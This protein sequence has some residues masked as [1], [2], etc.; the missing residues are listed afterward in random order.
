MGKDGAQ[1]RAIA[2]ECGIEDIFEDEGFVKREQ[3]S[4][5]QDQ[6]HINLLLTSSS[7]E[8]QGVLTGKLFDY[9]ESRRPVLC[10]INGVFDEELEA[11]FNK[12][13]LGKIFYPDQEMMIVQYLDDLYTEWK[14]TGTVAGRSDIKLLTESLSWEGQARKL[15][16][17][18]DFQF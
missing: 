6:S 17:V 8:H 5:V 11:F 7:P 16:D 10:M 13:N 2:S 18:L 15:M 1:M 3:A 14:N 4:L 12:Y 9:I